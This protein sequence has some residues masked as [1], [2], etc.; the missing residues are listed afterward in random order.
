MLCIKLLIYV[1]HT[2]N[3]LKKTKLV[4]K[5]SISKLIK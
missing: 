4:N 3:E 1:M 5:E 2:C